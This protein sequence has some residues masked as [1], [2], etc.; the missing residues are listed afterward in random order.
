MDGYI[1]RMSLKL[2]LPYCR[3]IMNRAL[4]RL[5]SEVQQLETRLDRGELSS[6]LGELL[7]NLKDGAL[8]TSSIRLSVQYANHY[9]FS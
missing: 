4:D 2:G 5:R 3:R 8:S 7:Q 1:D 9:S 6:D